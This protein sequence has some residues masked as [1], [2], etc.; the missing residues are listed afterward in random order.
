MEKKY[1]QQLIVSI[2]FIGLVVTTLFTM[3][4]L[5]SFHTYDEVVYYDYLLNET[6]KD[7][8]LENFEVFKDEKTSSIGGGTL[9]IVNNTLFNEG[10]VLKV[11]INASNNKEQSISSEYVINYSQNNPKYFLDAKK[12]IFT[13]DDVESKITNITEATITFY[14]EQETKI[15]DMVLKVNPLTKAIGSNK[16]YRMENAY[17]SEYFMRLGKLVTNS[18]IEKEYS[19][20]SLEYRYVKDKKK[21]EYVVFN[22][23]TS[24]TSEYFNNQE[25]PIYYHTKEEGSLLDKELSVVVILSNTDGKD[26]YVFAIDLDVN[27]VGESNE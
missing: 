22:K 14:N 24:T 5:Y 12:M 25:M 10:Q 26:E 19:T 4:P 13:K 17:V 2:L 21:K 1:K 7:I 8:S 11:V 9:T 6:S 23:T 27:K 20:I 3:Y 18:K 16:Q 15:Y